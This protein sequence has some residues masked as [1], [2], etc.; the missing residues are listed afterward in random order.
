LTAWEKA[1]QQ[2]VDSWQPEHAWADAYFNAKDCND[3]FVDFPLR[4]EEESVCDPYP[5]TLQLRCHTGL[6]D[7]KNWQQNVDWSWE[8]SE[9]GY[10]CHIFERYLND[11]DDYVYSIELTT[12]SEDRWDYDDYQ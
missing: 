7:L 9:Y 4:T 11:F 10:G 6:V 1:W 8:F 5:T 2:H 12:E 3:K